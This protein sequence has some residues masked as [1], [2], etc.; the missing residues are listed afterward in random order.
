MSTLDRANLHSRYRVTARLVLDTALHIGGGES[1]TITDSPVVKNPAGEPFIPGSSVKGAFRSAVERLAPLLDLRTCQLSDGYFDCLSSNRSLGEQYQVIAEREGNQLLNS[2]GIRQALETLQAATDRYRGEKKERYSGI[3]ECRLTAKTPLFVF[4]PRFVRGVYRNHQTVDFPVVNG[5]AIIPGTSLK[6]VIR[7]VV[8]AVETCCFTLPTDWRDGTKT[9]QGR[10]I[11][12]YKSL[13]V[14]LPKGFEHCSQPGKDNR[15]RALC[16]ACRLFGSLDP[17]GRWAYAGNVSIGDA[18]SPRGEYTLMNYLTLDVL[19]T[20]KPEGR[21]G[22]YTLEDGETIKG[23]KFYRHSFPLD[24]QQRPP[25]RRGNP[26]RDRQ[27]KTVQPVGEGSVFGFMLE[28][29][30][31]SADELRLLLYGLV[32]EEGLWHKV[33]LG[34]PIGLGSACIE[35]FKWTRIDR[36]ARYR[37]LG[38]GVAEPL[39]GESLDTE[40]NE[41]LRP[42]HEGQTEALQKIRDILRPN[43]NVK[44]RYF[45]ETLS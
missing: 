7:S 3:L 20:P 13:K 15:P 23:R 40:L 14:R 17:K 45:L 29:T 12:K 6:G 30:E 42:Y 1:S 34:K 21:P 33:G 11:T 5:D 16:P 9:Y 28:Y 25:D 43:P 37:E 35:V 39:E 8:E 24:V 4:D 44:V 41:W 36:E 26:Q 38:G 27:N 22:A 10:G 19:S 18:I 31:L 32:L 2:E